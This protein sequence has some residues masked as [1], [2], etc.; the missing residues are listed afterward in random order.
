MIISFGDGYK[1]WAESSKKYEKK[2]FKHLE[3]I[4]DKFH[5]TFDVYTDLSAAGNHFVTLGKISS[6]GDEDKVEIDLGSTVNP[7]S[8]CTCIKN[9]FTANG[10]NWGGWYFMNGVLEAD[11]IKPKL[12]WGDYCNAGIDLTEAKKLTFWAR[13]EKGGEWVEFFAFGVGRNAETGTPIAQCPD[14]SKKL[15]LGYKK[16]SKNWRK[17]TIEL[18][19][20]DLS[21]VLGGFGWVTK[22]SKNHNQNIT[23]Y[24]D[25][26]QYDKSNLDKPRFLVSNETSCSSID[27]DKVMKNIAFTYDNALA[28]IAF[29][30]RGTLEDMKR[31]KLIADALVYAINNDRYFT[32]DRLRNAY[33]GGDLILFPGWKPHGKENTVRMPGWWDQK[34]ET[35]YEDRFAVSTHTG[36]IA[37][38]IIALLSYYEK[39]GEGQNCDNNNYCKAAIRLGE[40]I[41]AHTKDTRGAGGYTGGYEGREKTTNNPN[42][43]IKLQWKSTEHNIDVYVAFIRLYEATK[44]KIWKDRALHAKAFVEA[45]WDDESGHFW[46]GTLDD[47]ETK[48]IGPK[49]EDVN[50]WGLMALGNI[51]KY[52]RGIRWVEDNCYTEHCGFKGFDFNNDRDGVWFEGTA[53]MALAYQIIGDTTKAKIYLS[54]LEKAQRKASNNNGKG[55][56]AA[57]HDDLTTGFDWSYY[58]RLH[59]GATAWFIFAK[60]GYNPY[61]GIKA[62]HPIPTY[63]GESLNYTLTISKEGTGSGTITS[64]PSGISC[65]NDCV[66]SYPSGTTVILTAAATNGSTFTSWSG[67]STALENTCYVLMNT[68]KTII[69]NFSVSPKEITYVYRDFILTNVCTYENNWCGYA[70]RPN[71]AVIYGEMSKDIEVSSLYHKLDVTI[72]IPCNGWGEGLA[73]PN[74]S[75]AQIIVNN[76]IKEEKIDSS[77]PYHHRGYYKYEYCDSF[78]NTFDISDKTLI[79]LIIRMNGGAR[80]DFQEAK[81]KF[82]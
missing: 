27:F 61:W 70:D 62:T 20:Q 23:F 44:D 30:S 50:T 80:L 37:W 33:Q 21:Y 76:I 14:S 65:G 45:M 82:Y 16:L 2:A 26:I 13:G 53:H 79:R 77:M 47:G 34:A 55:I 22:A 73:G 12:N 63:N 15:S 39:T 24:L 71:K 25:D 6:E 68:N 81:L 57:C 51:T 54:E 64:S 59:I 32:D 11:E 35:W 43:Q 31:A 49:P 60:K 7:H 8:G 9:Q 3:T 28:L 4:M 40:W 67:C 17:Y 56:V 1:S 58:N 69:A 74:G 5:K 41:E 10:D 78:T 72:S 75:S 48:N 36:N 19:M 52:G 18:K 38:A 66:E 29:L 42:E 46:T